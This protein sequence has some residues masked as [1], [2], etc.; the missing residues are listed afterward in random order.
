MAALFEGQSGG[1]CTSTMQTLNYRS[2]PAAPLTEDDSA[3]AS[4]STQV[5]FTLIFFFNFTIYQFSDVHHENLGLTR[6][7][8]LLINSAPH[9]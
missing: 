3:H 9:Y 5:I 2:W 1:V 4:L 6:S 8:K 7:T